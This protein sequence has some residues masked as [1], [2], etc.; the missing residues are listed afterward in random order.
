MIKLSKL[1]KNFLII[2]FGSKYSG[3]FDVDKHLG[4]ILRNRMVDF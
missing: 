3:I 1:S 2:Y 4:R